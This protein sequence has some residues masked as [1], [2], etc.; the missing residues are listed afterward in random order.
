[1]EKISVTIM[2]LVLM[3]PVTYLSD[4]ILTSF[5]LFWFYRLRKTA[6]KGRIKEL[7]ARFFLF[8]A[9]ATLTGGHSHL[10]GHYIN[11]NYYHVIG[12][13]F[14]AFATYY[15]QRGS[16]YDYTELIRKRLDKVFLL[17]LVIAICTY[18][19]YQM[20]GTFDR[21]VHTVGVPGFAAVSTFTAIGYLGFIV[22]LQFNKFNKEK[23]AGSA[24]ILL[25]IVLSAGV[26]LLHSKRWSLG[27]YLNFNVLAHFVLI[28]CYYIYFLGMR[29]KIIAYEDVVE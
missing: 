20:F 13:C 18:F 14:A 26:L 8:M 28:F 16:A 25:G 11:H 27:P 7:Y 15:F 22:P 1:M 29:K 5:S 23:D 21:T 2:G 12:W 6:P 17:L 10:L 24:I 9:L 4:L 3:E 19:G